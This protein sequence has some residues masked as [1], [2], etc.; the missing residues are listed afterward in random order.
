VNGYETLVDASVLGVTGYFPSATGGP[1]LPAMAAT[2][3]CGIVIVTMPAASTPLVQVSTGGEGVYLVTQSGSLV[4]TV[5]TDD[6]SV[7][8]LDRGFPTG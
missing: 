4:R 7:V 1:D 3:M 6:D 5:P 8:V 2:G